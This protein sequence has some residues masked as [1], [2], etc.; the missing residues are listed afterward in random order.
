M[1]LKDFMEI[2][3]D[4][5]SDNLPKMKHKYGA[6]RLKQFLS[7]LKS[8]FYESINLI[9]AAGQQLVFL[10]EKVRPHADSFKLLHAQGPSVRTFGQKAM[11]DETRRLLTLRASITIARAFEEFLPATLH[12]TRWNSASRV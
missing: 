3:R 11:E 2:Y 8:S 1:D 6:E 7:E 9:D 4:N 10:P 5:N 12:R